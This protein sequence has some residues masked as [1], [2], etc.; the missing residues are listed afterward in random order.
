M[1][2]LTSIFHEFKEKCIVKNAKIT[3]T[4]KNDEFLIYVYCQAN[5]VN[6]KSKENK[7][8]TICNKHGLC[9][10]QPGQIWELPILIQIILV[11]PTYCST[12]VFS[13]KKKKTDSFLSFNL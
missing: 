5:D 1:P 11:R 6:I 2:A 10:Y 8:K 12:Y 9:Y 13:F 3:Y 4:R 7:L